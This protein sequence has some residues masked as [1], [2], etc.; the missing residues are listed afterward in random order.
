MTILFSLLT[1]H[2]SRH[3]PTSKMGCQNGIANATQVNLYRG[4]CGYVWVNMLTL[5]PWRVLHGSETWVTVWMV[6]VSVWIW[7]NTEHWYAQL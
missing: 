2:Q 1:N 7:V 5:S 3:H 4:L 6:F